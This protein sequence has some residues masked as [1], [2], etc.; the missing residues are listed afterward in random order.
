MCKTQNFQIYPCTVL[1]GPF[2][3]NADDEEEY[4]VEINYGNDNVN[5]GE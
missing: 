3:A 2:T 5:N 4:D 1:N